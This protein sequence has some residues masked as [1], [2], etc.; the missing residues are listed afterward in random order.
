MGKIY[1]DQVYLILSLILMTRKSHQNDNS[2][3]S[4]NLK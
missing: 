1:S 2:D 4:E 3:Q